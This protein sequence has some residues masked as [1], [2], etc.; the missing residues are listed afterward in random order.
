M[1]P[2]RSRLLTT[3]TI[4]APATPPGEGAI[5]IVR[6]S[7]PRCPAIAQSLFG[8]PLPASRQL[9]RGTYT[10]LAGHTLD[11][12]LWVHFPH[13]NSYTGEDLLELHL[14]GNPFLVRRVIADL[15]ARGAVLAEPG[16]FTRRAFLNGRMDLSQAEAVADLVQARSERALMAAHAQLAGSVGR[17]VDALTGRLIEVLA[18]LE[19]YLDFP[20]EDL[21]P[22]DAAGPHRDLAELARTCRD[23]ASTAP[24][25]ERLREGFRV[26]LIGRPNAG[27][28]S[29]LNALVGEDRA[30]VDHEP[31][32]TRDWLE[33]PLAEGGLLVRL[34]DTAGLREAAGRVEAAGVERSRA[35]AA[36]ADL[37]IWVVDR[38]AQPP[39][40][41]EIAGL[42]PDL[43]VATK[44]DLPAAD[45]WGAWEAKVP[46]HT[47]S[48]VSGG[49]IAVLR[50]ELARQAAT[51]GVGEGADVMVSARHA[52][53][54]ADAAGHLEAAREVLERGEPQE[55]AAVEARL[56]W[57]A[58][59]RITGRTDP[60]S[61]L[62]RLFASFC[63]GK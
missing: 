4:V 3:T 42:R 56:A 34:I 5:A 44:A 19:A 26:A 23:L 27:K 13:P 16:E 8:T 17:A 12:L 62:D 60:E 43:I 40:P 57:E 2:E 63:I 59:G 15:Q 51:V 21:P 18:A 11:D 29:L 41:A 14:H 7:G 39:D 53:A 45:G 58:L 55:L 28:S 32:T 6:L 10:D 46:L 35:V 54:L 24:A 52:T 38:T 1:G 36:D 9:Q 47:V 37:R 22:E 33:A 48:A 50:S 20:E 49:G 30:L 25:R 61:I 31:G